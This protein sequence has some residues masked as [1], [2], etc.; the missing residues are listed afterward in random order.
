MRWAFGC[1]AWRCYRI[2]PDDAS[3]DRRPGWQFRP[4][5]NYDLTRRT[6]LHIKSNALQWAVGGEVVP[7]H[8]GQSESVLR[9]T[10]SALRSLRKAEKRG[11]CCDTNA[12]WKARID[13][14]VSFRG[15]YLFYH[16]TPV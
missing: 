15:W 4:G 3:R 14:R 9:F 13:I 5:G 2:R 7:S 8:R 1:M 10:D 12:K 16:W 11:V 6:P